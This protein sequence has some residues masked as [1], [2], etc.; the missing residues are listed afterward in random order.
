MRTLVVTAADE[1]FFPLLD[2][3]LRSLQQWEPSP[4]TDIACF[5][6]GL[7]PDS[8]ASVARR[9]SH[10]IEP[11]WDLPVDGDL[12]AKAPWKR[13]LTVRPFLPRYFP[14]YDVYVWIDA[15]AWVQERFALEW[16]V[17]GAARGSLSIAP[18]AHPA[19]RTPPHV[20]RWRVGVMQAYF[21]PEAPQAIPQDYYFNAGVFALRSDAPHWALW[22]KW[23]TRGLEATGG[24]TCT[25]QVALNYAVHSE[26]APVS[27][28]PARC[29]WVC[30]LAL[31][32]FDSTDGKFCEPVA[33]RRRIGIL[34]LTLD[35]K[36]RKA[37]LRSKGSIR[38]ISLRFPAVHTETPSH[39]SAIAP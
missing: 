20:A 7:A 36:Y 22:A 35:S 10:L 11:G 5:D 34:H 27:V 3:L 1:A 9:V 13:A 25:D 33:P 16:L 15:D 14:G 26:R 28:L 39:L 23:L 30:H 21:G 31:P 24:K 6:L 12:R 8:R 29:N 19:Y 2:D 18:H 32:G 4:Y 17:A 38:T 37:E